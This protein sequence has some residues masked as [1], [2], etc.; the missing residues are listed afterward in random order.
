LSGRRWALSLWEAKAIRC[1]AKPFRGGNAAVRP[2]VPPI[3]Y[4]AIGT[5][6]ALE[7]NRDRFTSPLAHDAAPEIPP[8]IPTTPSRVLPSLLSQAIV[9]CRGQRF[10]PLAM[11]RAR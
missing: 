3:G 6:A 10:P 8:A 11:A 1:D 7:R 9:L 5:V 4:A 2:G